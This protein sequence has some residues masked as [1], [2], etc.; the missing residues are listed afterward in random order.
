[1]NDTDLASPAGHLD[2][3]RPGHGFMGP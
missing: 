1:V 2:D 3:L